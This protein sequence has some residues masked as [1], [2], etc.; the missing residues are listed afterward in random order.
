MTSTP[1]GFVQVLSEFLQH[2]AVLRKTYGRCTPI[3]LNGPPNTGSSK[4]HTP[5]LPIFIGVE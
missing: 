3:H 5:N 2:F 1:V 4:L